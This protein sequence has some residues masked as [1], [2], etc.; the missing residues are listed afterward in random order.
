MA[1]V[2]KRYAH[3]WKLIHTGIVNP[4]SDTLK[5]ALVTS[6]YTV[7][8]AHTQW[9]DVSAYEVA[10]GDGY[11]TGGVALA[12]PVATNT[13]ID[14]D[15]PVWTALTK[16]FRYVVCYASKT[17][18]G[19]TNPLV[20]YILPDSTPADIIQ[21]GSNYSININATDKLFYDPTPPS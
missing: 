6:A 16:T 15:D 9:A 10:S 13:T 12:S 19:L 8:L 17:A 2:I 11:S 5:L 20:F 7:S 3:T 21:I 1:V 14:F 18:G 4:Y